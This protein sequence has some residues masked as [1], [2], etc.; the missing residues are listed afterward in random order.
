MPTYFRHLDLSAYDFVVSFVAR[1]RV[2][3]PASAN[4]LHVCYCHTPMRYV[5]LPE[6]EGTGSAAFGDRR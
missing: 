5:W 2:G 6:L 1:V 4:A 3:R